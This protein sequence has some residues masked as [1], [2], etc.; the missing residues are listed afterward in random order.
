MKRLRLALPL[1]TAAL[2]AVGLAGAAPIVVAK[3]PTGRFPC[4]AIGAYGAVW[5]SNYGAGT[6]SRID[7]RRNRVVKRIRT[8]G[9]PAG[10]AIAAGS[11]W[12]GTTFGPHLYR[13][14]PRN[15]RVRRIPVGNARPAW[16]AATNDAVWV[17][18]GA[19]GTVG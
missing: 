5:V 14:N 15:N 3:I 7:P 19:D 2:V 4:A 16:L 12:V 18:N 1:L 11:V 10:L 13:I 9:R 17:A 8:P 6:I